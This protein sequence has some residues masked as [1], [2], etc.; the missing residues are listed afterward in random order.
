[1]L[2]IEIVQPEVQA[3]RLHLLEAIILARITTLD[4][5]SEESREVA[6]LCATHRQLSSQ[7]R[8]GRPIVEGL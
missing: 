7:V 8:R 1:M 5:L 4:F 6:A 3:I 2:A